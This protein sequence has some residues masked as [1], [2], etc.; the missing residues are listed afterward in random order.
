MIVT[1]ASGC[2][3]AFS[4]TDKDS[5]NAVKSW[6]AKV[7]AECGKIPMI[8][9]QTKSDLAASAVVTPDQVA[10]LAQELQLN[11]YRTSSKEN[12]NVKEAFHKLA[13]MIEKSIKAGEFV[14]KPGPVMN[15]GEITRKNRMG[16]VTTKVEEQPQIEQYTTEQE[17]V[18]RSEPYSQQGMDASEQYNTQLRDS[19]DSKMD[20]ESAKKE[21]G[22]CTIF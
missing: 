22:D 5:F 15:I 2:L 10:E 1:G 16:K 8:I 3:L 21:Q 17:Y 7:I 19:S 6:Q 14:S 18:Q 11:L 9:I 4:P 12:K 20:E 13:E